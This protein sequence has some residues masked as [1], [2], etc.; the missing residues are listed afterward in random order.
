MRGWRGLRPAERVAVLG[1]LA[2]GGSLLFPWYGI[3]LELFGGFSQTGLEAFGLG[4]AALV[5]TA[6]ASVGLVSLCAGG[7]RLPRPLS[8]G[9]L[10]V[11]AGAWMAILVAYL[12]L[13]RPAE[14]AGFERVRIRY[15]VIVALAGA[16]ATVLGGTRLRQRASEPNVADPV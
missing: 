12:A 10:L 11:V 15:G 6:V 4:H 9:A 13:D 16:A 7:Y 3:E 5:V 2:A 8:E 1:A 14:I